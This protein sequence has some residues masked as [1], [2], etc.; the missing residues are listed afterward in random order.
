[1]ENNNLNRKDLF[2]YTNFLKQAN[3]GFQNQLLDNSFNTINNYII[4]YYYSYDFKTISL[5]DFIQECFAL[6][7]KY[8]NTIN[9]SSLDRLYNKLKNN[10]DNYKKEEVENS[11]DI[12]YDGIFFKE[13]IKFIISKINDDRKKDIL[14]NILNGD[15]INVLSN[16][17]GISRTRIIQ[18][19][20]KLLSDIR[21]IKGVKKYYS[22]YNYDAAKF[23]TYRFYNYF[24]LNQICSCEQYSERIKKLVEKRNKELSCDTSQ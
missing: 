21:R 22:E 16:K 9:K 4:N 19:K 8:N 23:N 15:N 14:I 24:L 10:E 20:D 11:Y 1:M 2:Y 13:E 6:I 18:L 3:E 5:E 17:Y 12:D 7:L